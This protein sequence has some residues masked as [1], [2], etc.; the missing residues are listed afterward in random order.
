M[1]LP[2]GFLDEIRARVPIS[3]VVGK[4]VSWDARKSNPAKGDYWACCPFHEEKSPSFHVDDRKGFYHC[5]GCHAKGDHIAFL[6]ERENMGFL[7]AVEELARAAGLEMPARDPAGAQRAEKSRDLAQWMEEAVRFYRAQLQGARGRGALS[8]LSGRGLS[9]ETIARFD[10]G[11]AT[12]DRRTLFE[13]LRAKGAPE[14]AIVEA[15]LA[16]RPDDGGAPYDRFRDRVM[17]PIRDPRGRCIAFGG[18]AMSKEARAKYLNSPETPLFDKSRTLYN[19]GPARAAAAKAGALIVVEGYMDAIAL[20]QAGLE[21]AV[22]PLG[23]ALTEHHLKTLWRIADEPVIALDGDR[24]G[25]D[26]A[27]RA[28]DLAL[29]LLEAGKSLRFALM[30]PGKDPDDLVRGEGPDAMRAA[31]DAAEPI[32]ALLWRRETEG[33]VFDSPERRAAL[34]KRLRALTRTVA[35]PF[36]RRHY[37]EAFAEKRRELFRG[38]REAWR[39]APPAGG[40]VG[41]D[42][43]GRADAPATRRSLLATAGDPR[44]LRE[45]ALLWLFVEFPEFIETHEASIAD[46]RF[47]SPDLEELR[48]E[49]LSVA[50]YLDPLDRDA[51]QAQLARTAEVDVA[52]ALGPRPVLFEAQRLST[53][54]RADYVRLSLD[55]MLPRWSAELGLAS[56]ADEIG[57][58]LAEGDDWDAHFRLASALHRKALREPGVLPEDDADDAASAKGLQDAI[59]AQIWIKKGRKRGTNH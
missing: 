45:A 22:A 49:M 7:E 52:A 2:P 20:A 5:F 8:Y 32:I 18:R 55:E 39:P 51:L 28:A 53:L 48:S 25:Q 1:A 9:A 35:D 14:A 57:A 37:G 15:G 38:A 56:E 54:S 24:A 59:A 50:S 40:R 26:A 10:L 21:H 46:L 27:L 33:R 42:R 36:V 12:P 17:F 16:A 19:H 34:D 58:R 31:L 23:T 13:H 4:R 3:E 44:R 6:R 41:G 29:P 11:Y 47:E 43:R 30:P